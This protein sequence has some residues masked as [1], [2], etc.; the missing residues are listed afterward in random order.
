MVRLT[1][2]VTSFLL[3]STT[4]AAV[5]NVFPPADPPYSST[6]IQPQPPNITA[7]FRAHFMQ[8]RLRLDNRGIHLLI[9]IICSKNMMWI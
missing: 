9:Y 1:L 3:C 8:V 2:S 5:Q 4:I 6:F 7:E